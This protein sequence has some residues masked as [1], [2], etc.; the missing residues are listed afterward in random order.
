MLRGHQ[1][2]LRS[3]KKIISPQNSAEHTSRRIN[4]G[5]AVSAARVLLLALTE[6]ESW[7]Q[8]GKF[9]AELVP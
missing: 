1:H 2:L 7:R 8:S 4:L 3:T 5:I 6:P 9:A